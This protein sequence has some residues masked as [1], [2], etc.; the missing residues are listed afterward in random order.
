[1]R[2]IS[3]TWLTITLLAVGCEGTADQQQ[4]TYD[5]GMQELGEQPYG[6]GTTTGQQGTSDQTLGTTPSGDSQMGD[7]TTGQPYGSTQGYGQNGQA[8]PHGYDQP[9]TGQPSFGTDQT[10]QQPGQVGTTGTTGTQP[11]QNGTQ[12][13]QQPTMTGQGQQI[14]Q[15]GQAQDK[16]QLGQA[17]PGQQPGQQGTQIGQTQQ[18][19]GMNGMAGMQ[20]QQLSSAQ[21]TVQEVDFGQGEL[22]LDTQDQGRLTLHARP[23]DLGQVVQGDMIQVQYT[24]FGS[25][26]W[27]V[28]SQQAQQ[29][30]SA[31][32][33]PT[34]LTG[35]IEDIDPESGTLTVRGTEVMAHP[36]QLQNLS[37]GQFMQIEY[38]TVEQSNWA[39]TIQPMQGAPAQGS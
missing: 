26:N 8:T 18:Q 17:Q 23:F 15:T 6:D 7:D 38:V 13:G 22:T 19:P 28:P 36:S 1:M 5:E 3:L 16:S 9:Q 12:V 27:V 20:G 37:P 2:A 39:T 34:T 35:A 31:Y 25:E 32:G 29:N 4:Q 11:G 14:G 10:G 30:L 24:Q 33:T 21:G